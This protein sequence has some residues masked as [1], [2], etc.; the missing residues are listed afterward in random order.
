MPLRRHTDCRHGKEFATGLS[1]CTTE[2]STLF[3]VDPDRGRSYCSH[4]F[5]LTSWPFPFFTFGS[6]DSGE[7]RSRIL[8]LAVFALRWND[9]ENGQAKHDIVRSSETAYHPAFRSLAYAF[10][11]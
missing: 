2:L 8:S 9:L 6:A 3:E 5:E 10:A 7:G 4:P 1:P 11:T